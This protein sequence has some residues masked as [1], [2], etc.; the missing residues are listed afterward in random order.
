MKN[1]KRIVLI[2]IA[3]VSQH[4]P[5]VSQ[6]VL[7]SGDYADPTILKD[8]DDYYMTHSPFHYQPGFLIW[9]SRDL[10]NW[11]PIARAGDIW[12][13]SA[14]A[15]DLQKVGDTYY[16]YFPAN[17]TN[18]VITAKDIRGPWSKPKDL[19]IGGIDPGLLVT[20]KGERF[21]FTNMGA[22]TPLTPDGLARAGATTQVYE[23]WEY[24]KE[25]VTECMC[26]ESPK[27]TYH[28][29]YYY[30][31]SA[32]GGTAGPAT[33]HMAVC[34]RS[35]SVYGPWENSPYNPIVHT[36]SDQ[37]RWWS[38]GH[39][40]LVEGPD[41]QW[42]MVYHA[43]EKGAYSLGRQTLVEAIEWT[44]DGWYRLAND[45]KLPQSS[46][47][48]L[49][50]SFTQPTLG[51]Q[52][53]GWNEDITKEIRVAN[54]GLWML[55]KGEGPRDARLLLTTALHKQYSI[56][57][58][59]LLGRNGNKAGMILFYNEQAFAGVCADKEHFTVFYDAEQHKSLP[60]NIGNHI[61]LKIVNRGEL[62]DVY[63]SKDKTDWT[64]IVSDVVIEHMHHNRYGGFIALRPALFSAGKG[65][66]KFKDFVYQPQ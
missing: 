18:W 40:S 3:V 25:W 66:S 60:N 5:A 12:S 59:L 61:F 19:H 39:G 48:I 56:E 1:I 55:A 8:G 52:W 41:G 21:L 37:E 16:I 9:H 58:E 44:N 57:V 2:L 30:M 20:P 28:N 54:G 63:V 6:T 7:L 38:K 36:Y 62:M 24:P 43:Y 51:W 29:G 27:L 22:V 10:V 50:D 46:S 64:A 47:P 11:K 42:W 17:E 23:G 35:K 14:W 49:S 13:G 65:K 4:I 26:L 45:V 34:A 15:P 31:T 53:T 32:Q 33:S